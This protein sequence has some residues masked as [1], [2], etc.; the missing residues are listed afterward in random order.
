MKGNV[1]MQNC[2]IG[3][4]CKSGYNEMLDGIE[5]K[6]LVYGKNTLLCEFKLAKGK[7]LPMHKHPQ[8]Q[9]GYLV[10]GHIILIINGERHEMK[11]GD[12]WTIQ[13]NIEHGAEIKEDSIAVEVF[14]PVREDYK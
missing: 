9:T 3:K 2:Q 5:R 12:S 6:T 4:A 13:G 10:A 1:L 14:S 11:Q 8:E 7:I